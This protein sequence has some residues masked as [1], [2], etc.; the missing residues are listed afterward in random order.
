MNL[1]TAITEVKARGF[2]Y[3]SDAR[4][5]IM[6]NNAK[7][8]LE[9]AHDWPWLEATQNGVAPLTITDLRQILYVV[10]TTND[11]LLTGVD[12]RDIADDTTDT[13]TPSYWYLDGLTTLRVWPLATPTLSVRYLKYSPELT[14]TDTPLI[15]ARYHPVWVDLATADAFR[16]NDDQAQAQAYEATANQRIAEMIENFMFRDH[17]GPGMQALTFHAEDW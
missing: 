9:D 7:N 1:A 6:L 8:R 14:G 17:Q 16:D 11:T 13:G 3:L 5:T 10:D 2:D 12:V 4:V 15:P